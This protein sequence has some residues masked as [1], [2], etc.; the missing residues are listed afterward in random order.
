MF[1]EQDIKNFQE[2]Y[3]NCCGEELVFEEASILANNMINLYR[4]VLTPCPATPE[5]NF[6]NDFFDDIIKKARRY[7]AN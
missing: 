5:I 4:I 1:T 2:I 6:T 7:N 3:R